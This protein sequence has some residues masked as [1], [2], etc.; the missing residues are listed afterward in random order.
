ME[1]TP[2]ALE[3]A[4]EAFGHS[5]AEDTV[6][7]ALVAALDAAIKAQ[8][9]D[10]KPLAAIISAEVSH[11]RAEALEEAAALAVENDAIAKAIRALK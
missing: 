4:Y 3:A 11:T 1:W 9:S 10:N 2:A 7:D 5:P 6:L 8:F